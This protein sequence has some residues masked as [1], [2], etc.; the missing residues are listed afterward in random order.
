MPTA[1]HLPS[2]EK[3]T[4]H[5]WSSSGPM[6]FLLSVRKSQNQ[7][8]QSSRE[9]P[10]KTKP[11]ASGAKARLWNPDQALVNV[12]WLQVVESQT[13]N[14]LLT[15]VASSLPSGENTSGAVADFSSLIKFHRP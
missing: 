7:S 1:S 14:P 2:G 4:E 5:A 8:R 3:D 9:S 15:V 11:P 12:R 10:P 13:A 6:S